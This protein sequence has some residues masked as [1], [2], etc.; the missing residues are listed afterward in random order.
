MANKLGDLKSRVS[1]S[2]KS[3]N[4]HI[5]NGGFLNGFYLHKVK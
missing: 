4:S 5:M 2:K 1:V 3:T